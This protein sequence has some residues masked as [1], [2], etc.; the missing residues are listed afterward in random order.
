[1]AFM[2]LFPQMSFGY[3]ITTVYPAYSSYN[4][5]RYNYGNPPPPPPPPLVQ[6]VPYNNS[7]LYNYYNRVNQVQPLI[8]KSYKGTKVVL[9]YGYTTSYSSSPYSVKNYGATTVKQYYYPS[10][11]SSSNVIRYYY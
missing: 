2:F 4:Y 11:N 8:S 10:S 6:N 7:T 3:K 1:M 9:P 5:G